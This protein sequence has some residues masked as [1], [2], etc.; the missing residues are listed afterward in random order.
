MTAL[1]PNPARLFSVDNAKAAKAAGFGYLNAILYMAPADAAGVGNLCPHASA[2][3]RAACLGEHSG[4]A[5]IL[6][7]GE[8]LNNTRR[9]RILRAQTFMRDRPTFMRMLATG[10]ARLARTAQKADLQ[11]CVRLNGATDIAWEGCAVDVD[12]ATARAVR[13]AGFPCNVQRYPSLMALFSTLQFIEYTKNP[14]RMR[15]QARGILPANL[16]LTFSRSEENEEHVRE[17]LALGQ[18]VAAVFGDGLPE[19]YHGVPVI[20]GDTH[21]L[22]HLDVRGR[23]VGLT[24]KGTKAKRDRTSGFILWGSKDQAPPALASEL[25]ALAA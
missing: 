18:N 21:D 25:V 13:A 14:F 19:T 6:K 7:R 24:P 3:C 11:L 12:D 2:G 8:T 17:I 9:A 1:P 20:N 15:K 10:I 16:Y 5:A 23:V 22:R 4:Q